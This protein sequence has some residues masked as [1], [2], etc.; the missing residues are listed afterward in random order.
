M[1]E[2]SPQIVAEEPPEKPAA[3]NGGKNALRDSRRGETLVGIG[4]PRSAPLRVSRPS[5]VDQAIRRYRARSENRWRFIRAYTT[6][7]RVIG[8]YLWLF[9]KAKVLGRSYRDQ[10]IAEVHKR[11]ARLV[12]ETILQLQGLFIK[13]GQALSIMANFLPEAFRAELEGLQDQVPPRPFD[14]VEPRIQEDLGEVDQLFAEFKREPIASA[15]LGQVHEARTK[16]GRKVAVKVQ[17]KDIDEIVRLDLKTIRRIM[18]IVQWF[19][20]VQGLDA[21]YHQIKEL[22]RQELDFELEA[23]NIEKIAKNFAPESRVRFPTPVRELSTKRVLTTTFVEGKKLTDTAGLDAMGIDKKD[24]AN[25]LV[26]AY[27]QMIFVD[28]VYH[29]DPH[30]GNILVDRDGN[31]ILLDFGAVAELSQPMREGIPEFLEGV[32]RRDTDRLIKALRK[33]GFLSRTSDEAMTEKIIEYFH[34]RFQEEVKLESF[35]LKDIK[36]DPQ[37]GFENLLDLRKMNVGLK[38]LS[39]AFHVPRDWVLLERTILLTYGSCALLDPEL[40]PMA[41]IQPYLQDFVLGNRDWREIAMETVRDMA[42][43]AVTLPDDLRKYLVKATRGEMEVRVK[44]VQEG[45]KAIYA[46]GRQLIYT[47]I[48]IASGAAALSLHERGEDGTPTTILLSIT[49]FCAFM[50]VVSSVFSRP[51]GR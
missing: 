19:V 44:G 12:Y 7:F 16:D 45:T 46:V 22:L 47:A 9:W 48:G 43:G 18:A 10:N 36:I 41:I 28:G 32:I 34:R 27:C 37:R 51:R 5:P 6:T 1:S 40:N 31:I 24:L 15:S 23:D 17:H 25:R 29:A 20:P 39:G 42:L 50:L 33:M 8:S 13:V 49:G 30:P 11:N 26:R 38:E 2:S 3:T 14:E 4:D 35:N 21:Y